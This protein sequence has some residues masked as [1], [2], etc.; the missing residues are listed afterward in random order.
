LEAL[1]A[2]SKL[3]RSSGL[4]EAICSKITPEEYDLFEDL[5]DIVMKVSAERPDGLFESGI[6]SAILSCELDF[7]DQNLLKKSINLILSF[8][9]I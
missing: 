8:I 1:P 9:L 3:F 6:L 4:I 5:I 7:F 2:V